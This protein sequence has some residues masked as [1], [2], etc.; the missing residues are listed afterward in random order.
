MR[1]F[2][3]TKT[4]R[5]EFSLSL[6]LFTFL[7]GFLSVG[8]GNWAEFGNGPMNP[9]RSFSVGPISGIS[10]QTN[11]IPGGI[12]GTFRSEVGVLVDFQ[13]DYYVSSYDPEIQV[14]DHAGNWAGAYD[15]GVSGPR[16]V[17]Y[18]SSFVLGRYSTIFTGA[19]GGT[20][21]FHAIRVDKSVFPYTLAL[22]DSD[23]ATG[24]S[25]SSPKR[26]S[27][28][29]FYICDL[30]GV[31]HR[32]TYVGG[33]L[34]HKASLALGHEVRGAIALYDADAEY[35]GQEV[36]V[37]TT[38]GVFYVLDHTLSTIIWSDTSGVGPLG[39]DNYYAGVTVA[40]RGT[41]SPVALLPI[42]GGPAGN[43]AANSGKVRA[44]DLQSQ[45]MAWELIPSFTNPGFDAIEGSVAVLAE[46]D[47]PGEPGGGSPG[48]DGTGIVDGGDGNPP[49]IVVPTDPGSVEKEYHATFAS[50]DGFLYG[51]DIV[52][53]VEVW[54]YQMASSGFE[55]PVVDDMNI[56]YVGDGKSNLHAVNGGLSC[57][58][59]FLWTDSSLASGA[60]TDIVKL[61]ITN[62]NA[63]VVGTG[64]RAF[65]LFQ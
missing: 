43:F 28:G 26:A 25:E 16:A 55:A 6:V 50:T 44:F 61:G 40:E 42:A 34:A 56:I 15:L 47:S 60:S 29:T 8:C 58:G 7:F 53:G 19:T 59:C 14:Y 63:L 21:G 41:K 33:T 57:A 24:P 39:S 1:N 13:G 30:G 23:S 4:E 52:S 51:V 27:D 35:P 12:G 38:D 49:N 2:I 18:V 3:S 36:L 31:V 10:T 54:A 11:I 45:A 46:Q 37:A 64:T 17:P 62:T 20:G 5:T 9:H 65:A 32:Y 48:G 22:M